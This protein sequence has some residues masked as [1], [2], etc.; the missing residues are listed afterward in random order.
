MATNNNGGFSNS[1]MSKFEKY[2]DRE[3]ERY[4]DS[5]SLNDKLNDLMDILQS[6]EEDKS[7]NVD[8]SDLEEIKQEL[9]FAKQNIESAEKSEL[10]IFKERGISSDW[11]QKLEEYEFERQKLLKDQLTLQKDLDSGKLDANAEKVVRARIKQFDKALKARK[12]AFDDSVTNNADLS[13]REKRAIK[14]VRKEVDANKS[15]INS[16]V[17]KKREAK[18]FLDVQKR[19]LEMLR[20]YDREVDKTTRKYEERLQKYKS[21]VNDIAIVL[22]KPLDKWLE[23][24]KAS[25]ESA[26]AIGL[27]REQTI[28]YQ[29]AISRTAKELA[30]TYGL[31]F[32]QSAKLQDMYNDAT[33]RAAVLSTNQMRNVAAMTTLVGEQTTREVIENMDKL[34]GGVEMATV[35]IGKANLKARAMGLNIVKASSAFAKNMSMANKY[36]FKNGVDGVMRM[37]ML[38]QKLK[39]NLESMGGVLDKF[40]NISDAIETSA[41][42]Q[43]MG[44][45]AAML[46][47]NPL[48]NLYQGLNDPEALV[49]K[50]TKMF[51]SRAIFNRQ[52]GEAELKGYNL[53]WVRNTAQMLGLNAD[54]AVQMAKQSA[55]IQAIDAEMT[56]SAKSNKRLRDIIESKAEYDEKAKAHKV[57]YLDENG[58][59]KSV[60]VNEIFNDE[61]LLKKLSAQE[62]PVEDIQA[63]VRK[64]AET[65]TSIDSKI[66]GAKEAYSIATAEVFENTGAGNLLRNTF[67]GS[68]TLPNNIFEGAMDFFTNGSWGTGLNMLMG[69]LGATFVGNLFKGNILKRFA[70]LRVG[71]PALEQSKEIETLTSKKGSKGGGTR[72][73]GARNGGGARNAAR[74]TLAQQNG[75]PNNSYQQLN[76]NYYKVD[77]NG[78]ATR[79]SQTTYNRAVQGQAQG[80]VQQGNTQQNTATN[81]RTTNSTRATRATRATRGISRI[82][83]R[84]GRAAK[85]GGSIGGVI[86]ALYGIYEGYTGYK[87]AKAQAQ[88]KKQEI[89]TN[90]TYTARQKQILKENNEITEQNNK[91][92]AILGASGGFVGGM[93]GGAAV[94]SLIGGPVGTIIGGLAGGAIGAISGT[95]LGKSLVATDNRTDVDVLQEDFETQ[96]FG[97]DAIAKSLQVDPSG[98][99]LKLLAA[100]ATIKMNDVLVSIWNKMNGK[101]SNGAVE[102]K[103]FIDNVADKG[104]TAAI[105]GVFKNLFASDKDK[106]SKTHYFGSFKGEGD[107]DGGN[108]SKSISIPQ[109]SVIGNDIR[110]EGKNAGIATVNSDEVVMHREKIV[111][112]G[113]AFNDLANTT[114]AVSSVNLKNTQNGN[115]TNSSNN[116]SNAISNANFSTNGYNMHWIRATANAIGLDFEE[117]VK[118]AKA[119]TIANETNNDFSNSISTFKGDNSTFVTSNGLTQQYTLAP[120]NQKPVNA[121]YVSPMYSHPNFAVQP[122][123]F[124]LDKLDLNINLS[125]SIDL[126]SDGMYSG[127]K[128]DADKLMKDQ[129]YFMD[130]LTYII[131]ENITRKMHGGQRFGQ[132][133]M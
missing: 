55:K 123:Q 128:L 78:K 89:E 13:D 115:I 95:K 50:A 130:R 63:H 112:L 84:L 114:N 126:K 96:K 67:Q 58:E 102:Q 109:N 125:G 16:I 66:K 21:I 57:T 35:A 99:N 41:N 70:R 103:G 87:E 48:E 85:V 105:G 62:E 22:K 133:K 52:T 77:G 11:I 28:A 14:K 39:F 76:G 9:R 98:E 26:K 74:P 36:S 30:R 107:I 117:A 116:Q 93:L 33:D 34:G 44:G 101:Q 29:K 83:S 38:A 108:G 24:E 120:V 65:L 60:A 86:G 122:P 3:N 10:N 88:I 61:E 47:G 100:Q 71:K 53:Q 81:R 131:M 32:E 31:S 118:L 119:S 97:L 5:R 7:S 19:N 68:G 94:G 73:S 8:K 75:W 69:A 127:N 92:K 40:T 104:I 27:N 79:I 51:A 1:F 80:G 12:Q 64:L 2:F 111:N 25:K 82:T 91:T 4:Y 106:E 54:E 59:Q 6:I 43:M 17:E 15:E 110:Q 46:F 37:T 56:N 113:N 23:I 72:G 121:N 20:Q 124:G 18:E 42:L 132:T 129:P 90:T 49:E 45:E